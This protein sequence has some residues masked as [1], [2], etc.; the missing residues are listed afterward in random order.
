MKTRNPEAP[1]TVLAS[2]RRK[3]RTRTWLTLLCTSLIALSA[4]SAQEEGQRA[5]SFSLPALDG[6]GQIT[7]DDHPGKVVYLDFWA[8]WCPPCLTSLPILDGLR[9]EFPSDRFEV[10]AVNVDSDPDKAR[11]FLKKRPVGY[12]S[13]S[14]PEGRLPQ[15]FAIETMPTSFLIDQNGVVRH[16]HAG[17]RKSDVDGLREK[18]RQLVARVE[19]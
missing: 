7:L 15:R 3:M 4:A 16:V 19:R 11:A 14:D 5:P 6:K 8:S 1:M 17:F 9:T 2:C 18:I 10:L 12:R 13:A